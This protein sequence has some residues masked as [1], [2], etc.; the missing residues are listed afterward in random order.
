M[1]SDSTLLKMT[2]LAALIAVIMLSQ[3]PF[4]PSC[5]APSPEA[6]V[7]NHL[8]SVENPRLVKLNLAAMFSGGEAMRSIN[9]PTVSGPSNRDIVD[10]RVSLDYFD[11]HDPS[12][13]LVERTS[14]DE[15]SSVFLQTYR[16]QIQQAELGDSTVALYFG[17]DASNNAQFVSG[18]IV[19][20]VSEPDLPWYFIEPARPLMLGIAQHSYG[21]SPTVTEVETCL[22]ST[23]S[24]H[25]IYR[26]KD[27][28]RDFSLQL[29]P[30]R[31][32]KATISRIKAPFN[33]IAGD[34]FTVEATIENLTDG[35]LDDL[36][37]DRHLVDT[38]VVFL[39]DGQVIESRQS[40]DVT[41]GDPMPPIENFSHS[42]NSDE[43][44]PHRLT[45]RTDGNEMTRLIYVLE[46]DKSSVPDEILQ[47][48]PFVGVADAAF[49]E[50]Y[51]Q[52]DQKSWWDSQA[53]VLN[54]V[55][56]FYRTQIADF[57]LK[58]RALEAWTNTRGDRPGKPIEDAL[59]SYADQSE[60]INAYT[61][62]C[63][64]AQDVPAVVPKTTPSAPALVHLFSG[65][66][67]GPVPE[68]M[69]VSDTGGGFCQSTCTQVGGN[70]VGLAEGLAGYK[71]EKSTPNVRDRSCYDY[72]TEPRELDP[73]AYHGLSQHAPH[74]PEA[75][76]FQT[77]LVYEDE[78][79]D[80]KSRKNANSMYQGTLHQRFLLLAHEIGHNL[81]ANHSSDP[82]SIMYTP[83][84]SSIRF[85]LD[86]SGQ[87]NKEEIRVC[88]NIC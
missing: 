44:G 67:L 74:D 86:E 15:T 52:M 27:T 57:R 20:S 51:Q 9:V 73:A 63:N 65:E 43:L 53:E 69:T 59:S 5:T 29:E 71:E 7:Q 45:V 32:V 41:R 54:L 75:L 23:E 62:L 56:E 6:F 49:F 3:G 31:D 28:T 76:K 33:V 30:A 60:V 77:G 17:T 39:V 11:M 85:K 82:T 72:L 35:Q 55:D 47:P 10:R 18:Y 13:Q 38:T 78:H 21:R 87:R 16:G 40:P 22:S 61:L 36:G 84:K 4:S 66:D 70:V 64:F 19:E 50:L 80:E 48:I 88:W 83:L 14:T 25:V 34:Q 8:T 1:I 12:F 26:A 42:F 2:A 68:P 79:G 37:T 58:V 24:W 81:G 46:S